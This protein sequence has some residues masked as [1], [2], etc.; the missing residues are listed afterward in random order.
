MR[1]FW[2]AWGFAVLLILVSIGATAWVFAASDQWSTVLRIALRGV[3]LA[4][5]LAAFIG[6]FRLALLATAS[7]RFVLAQ[8]LAALIVMELDDLRQAAQEHATALAAGAASEQQELN[9]WRPVATLQIPRFF[10][11]RHEIRKLLGP[12]TEHT[13]EQLL[14]SLQTYNQAVVEA[15]SAGADRNVVP[16]LW[17]EITVVQERLRH[18]ALEV[19]PF[20][21]A[22]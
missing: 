20:C 13:L 8:N 19:A 6:A 4:V 2:M 9:A 14:T 11:D 5:L 22:N 3:S 21:L 16:Q 17:Q 7:L 10:G 15:K 12:A 18:A 1:L